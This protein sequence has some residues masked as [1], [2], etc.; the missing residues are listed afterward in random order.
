MPKRSIREEMLQR[1]RHL[2]AATCL[3]SSLA[4]QRRL[5]STPEFAAALTVALYCPTRNEV[6]TEELFA[7]ARRHGKRVA[8]PRVR[9]GQLE[10]VQVADLQTLTPGAFGILEPVG[11]SLLR[12]GELD[13]VVVPGVAFDRRGHRL[14]YGKGFYDRLLHGAPPAVLAGLCF[15]F[16]LVDVLPHEEH[17]VCM[18]LLVT[19][20]RTL[21]FSEVPLARSQQR[22]STLNTGRN[23]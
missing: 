12:L 14:G 15:D 8:Y 6:F 18:D 2:A 1:R 21:M 19:D 16:Q 17:D 11:D 3:G 7:T 4:A 23:D 13:L 9:G 10:F 20:E 22:Q 5:L